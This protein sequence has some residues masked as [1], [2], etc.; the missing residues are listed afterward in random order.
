MSRW[1]ELVLTLNGGYSNIQDTFN[2]RIATQLWLY[3]MSLVGFPQLYLDFPY[4]IE[5][6]FCF[7]ENTF[8]YIVS[9]G[10]SEFFDK[11]ARASQYLA[12]YES[13]GVLDA[14]SQVRST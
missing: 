14:L 7:I 6:V 8:I 9:V 13:T 2:F 5:L 1:Y 10:S 3:R 4:L 11:L 12:E